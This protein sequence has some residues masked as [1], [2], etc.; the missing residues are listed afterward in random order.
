VRVLA[1]FAEKGIG[2]V[3]LLARRD[4]ERSVESGAVSANGESATKAA[5][6]SNARPDWWDAAIERFYDAVSGDDE[7]IERVR[8][9]TGEVAIADSLDDARRMLETHDEIERVV[10]RDGSVMVA[11]GEAVGGAPSAGSAVLSRRG[12]IDAL[13][14]ERDALARDLAASNAEFADAQSGVANA[15][16]E[17]DGLS[18]AKALHAKELAVIDERLRQA[19]AREKEMR[20]NLD[21]VRM[22]IAEVESEIARLDGEVKLRRDEKTNAMERLTHSEKNVERV[23][24]ALTD[25]ERLYHSVRDEHAHAQEDLRVAHLNA[26][27]VESQ[28]R[29]LDRRVRDARAQI[30]SADAESESLNAKLTR[31]ETD[32]AE[33]RG[34]LELARG[35][36]DAR[37]DALT[38]TRKTADALRAR[39]DE[40]KT[41]A[42]DAEENRTR[43]ERDLAR[44]DVTRGR[45]LYRYYDLWKS[46][47]DATIAMVGRHTPSYAECGNT[48]GS[49][50]RKAD[51]ANY[52]GFSDADLALINA[53]VSPAALAIANEALTLARA[54]CEAQ[55]IVVAEP[56]LAGKA[57][58][59]FWVRMG[60]APQFSDERD[61]SIGETG[62]SG[63]NAG[64]ARD[65]YAETL[66]GD[67]ERIPPS[68]Q[69]DALGHR[70]DVGLAGTVEAA[71]A[72]AGD[73]AEQ[74][75]IEDAP[76]VTISGWETYG[77]PEPPL[78]PSLLADVE[79]MG[80]GALRDAIAECER[81]I[82][83]LGSVNLK[84]PAQ[85]DEESMR[86]SFFVLQEADV[87]KAL[88][89]LTNLL[90][91]LDVETLAKYRARAE[92][93][94]AR[95]RDY[96]K[97][98]F[99]SG[100]ATVSF[101]EPDNILESGVEVYVTLPGDRRQPLRSLSGGER[102][103]IFLALFLAAHATGAGAFCIMDEADAALD[104]ANILRFGRLLDAIA[105]HTQLILITHNKRTMEL[106][107]GLVG[108]VGRPKGVSRVIPVNLAKAQEYAEAGVASG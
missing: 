82:G 38:A 74:M 93:I 89:D 36:L 8:R 2:R 56:K 98:L 78:P 27:H 58:A 25:C 21:S 92:K 83:R 16:A 55:G 43:F 79:R 40:L 80:K 66:Y 24:E 101:T 45:L 9:E 5:A 73:S 44:F 23:A 14:R 22:E 6:D 85:W 70:G 4:N 15:Q 107:D 61:G 50:G 95:F 88:E 33:A 31:C 91:S 32:R 57:G 81:A 104:D 90:A 18:E 29:D 7:L 99:G 87:R 34:A 48:D 26:A 28:T 47:H 20:L 30:K 35:A 96:F 108:I 75:H 54:F 52:T 84:A 41:A 68:S 11:R 67:V 62:K 42:R 10:L 65:A 60:F 64:D 103:L 59:A 71:S 105:A 100:D 13:A 76:E 72:I 37:A 17:L 39:L 106:A 51:Y 53:G 69:A 3:R 86:L 102:S 94:G 63:A 1:E 97:F 19:R 12:A 49:V 46:W 77:A